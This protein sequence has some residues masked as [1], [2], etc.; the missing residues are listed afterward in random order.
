MTRI[1]SLLA[2]IALVILT[3]LAARA[4]T[5]P[6]TAL[7]DALAALSARYGEKPRVSQA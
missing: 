6:C 7:P 2:A 3:G 4:Q 1:L 5:A